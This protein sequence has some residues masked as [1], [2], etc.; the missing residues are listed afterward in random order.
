MPFATAVPV[1][2][3]MTAR[4]IAPTS[5]RTPRYSAAVWP[6]W[7][8]IVRR[9][10]GRPGRPFHGPWVSSSAWD[11]PKYGG[12]RHRL[13]PPSL[14]PLPPARQVGG[15]HGPH[16]HR[17][18]VPARGQGPAQGRLRGGPERRGLATQR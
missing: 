8:R 18:E 15:G 12:G 16:G 3:V 1:P 2:A 7:S 14:V 5:S 10:V 9:T 17:G 11:L 6:R 13:Q 4:T